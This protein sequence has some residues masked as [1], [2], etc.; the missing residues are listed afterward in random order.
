MPAAVRGPHHRAMTSRSRNRTRDLPVTGGDRIG[1][2]LAHLDSALARRPG[3]GR[4]TATSTTILRDGLRCVT[5]EREH[6]IETDLP[7]ALGG[8]GS[9]PTP[10]ALLRAALG[11][12]LAMGYRLRAARHGVALRA[13]EVVV[14]TDSDIAGLLDPRSAAPAGFVDVRYRVRIESSAPRAQLDAIVD[15]ADASSPVLDTL[16]RANRVHRSVTV[17][18]GVG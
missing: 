18:D 9:A 6:E 14:E 12:C 13:V 11:S 15:E 7:T 3:F 10:S 1:Q 16:E 5:T 8:D 17:V 4:S 2:A